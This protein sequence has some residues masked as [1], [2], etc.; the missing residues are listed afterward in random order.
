MK[1]YELGLIEKN[2][3]DEHD[4]FFKTGNNEQRK[5]F[6]EETKQH[7]TNIKRYLSKWF[8]E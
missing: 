4:G 1:D 2:P 6:A 5:S 7:L 3:V 8:V